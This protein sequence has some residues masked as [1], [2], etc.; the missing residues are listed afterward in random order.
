MTGAVQMVMRALQEGARLPEVVRV[1]TQDDIN[2]YAEASGDA[3]PIHVD[4]AFA[5]ST[6][7]GGT[8]AHGLACAAFLSEIMVAQAGRAWF[9]AGVLEIKFVRPVRPGDAIRAHGRITAVEPS[10]RQDGTRRVRCEVRCTNQEGTDVIVGE[11]SYVEQAGRPLPDTRGAAGRFW[12][13]AARGHL[14]VQ[15]CDRCQQGIFPPRAVC[16]RC[17]NPEVTW[18]EVPGRG[19]V[20]SY[21]VVRRARSPYFQGKEPY[22]VAL[23]DLDAGGRMMT[24]LVDVAPDQVRVGMRVSVTYEAVTDQIGL[25]LFRPEVDA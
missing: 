18:R 11:A 4:E 19:T 12:A 23:V 1:I 8:I 25:P 14:E 13:A 24:N 17:G 20:Y 7:L 10:D 16:H 2:R 9:E 21:T 3:N 5:R 15:W 6:A 22:V